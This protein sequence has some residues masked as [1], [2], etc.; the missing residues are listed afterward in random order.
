VGIADTVNNIPTFRDLVTL[1]KEE[2][3]DVKHP[4]AL[5]KAK[6]QHRAPHLPSWL[7]AGPSKADRLRA[8]TRTLR[9]H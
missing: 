3:G 6:C 9:L 4:V 8:H 2:K 7:P 1:S 5:N